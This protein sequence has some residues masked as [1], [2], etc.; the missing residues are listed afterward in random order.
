MNI[1]TKIL[2]KE[3]EKDNNVVAILGYGSFFDE[4]SQNYNDIDFTVVTLEPVFKS[5][6]GIHFKINDIQIDCIYKTIDSFYV[7]KPNKKFDLVYLESIIIY[8]RNDIIDDALNFIRKNWTMYAS[9]NEKAIFSYRFRLSTYLQKIKKNMLHNQLF[10]NHIISLSIID[11][12]NFYILVSKLR[13]G[14]YKNAYLYMKEKNSTLYN[15]FYN[16][17]QSYSVESKLI[18]LEKIINNLLMPFNGLRRE[19]EIMYHLID[20]D[21]LIEDKIKA[22]LIIKKILNGGE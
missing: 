21:I 20:K 2:F 6:N 10:A 19:D 12:L 9:L 8:K 15:N 5:I 4:I 16:F 3:F 18:Y 17:Y 22:N 11:C 14:K 1:N 13:L 7:L